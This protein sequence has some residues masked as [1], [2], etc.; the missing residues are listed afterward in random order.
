M[1]EFLQKDILEKVTK[2]TKIPNVQ[3]V[4]LLHLCKLAIF[5]G[6]CYA[7]FVIRLLKFFRTLRVFVLSY[8]FLYLKD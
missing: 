6:N 2:S 4:V 8:F 7:H 5:V 3:S 1:K